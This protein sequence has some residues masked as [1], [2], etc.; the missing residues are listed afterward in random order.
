M[1]NSFKMDW[2]SQ[3]YK[4]LL[5][6]IGTVIVLA[7]L[8]MI[9]G[10]FRRHFEAADAGLVSLSSPMG[11]VSFDYLPASP[12]LKGWKLALP[13]KP[14]LKTEAAKDCPGGLRIEAEDAIDL[15]V[16]EYLKVCNRVSF[17]AK[18]SADSYVYA[19]IRMESRDGESHS[20]VGWIACAIGDRGPRRESRDEWV[21]YQVPTKSGWSNYDLFLPDVVEQ[22]FGTSEGLKFSELLGFRLR[23]TLSITRISLYR[24]EGP[25]PTVSTQSLS[26][27]R[28]RLPWTRSD[29]LQLVALAIATLGIVI[30]L[31]RSFLE[32]G[33]ARA[34]A[35]VARNE[36]KDSDQKVVEVQSAKSIEDLRA[37]NHVAPLAEAESAKTLAEIPAESFGYVD[38]SQFVEYAVVNVSVRSHK[39]LNEFE[40]H[41]LADGDGI[42]V[43][44]VGPETFFR[45]MEG[46]RHGASL[47]LYSSTWKEAPKLVGVAAKSIKCGRQR[48]IYVDNSSTF[49]SEVDALDCEAR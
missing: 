1:V 18:L 45:L 10:L 9:V 39:F 16:E 22:T 24:D 40:I 17:G 15:G 48:T 33:N 23:G 49:P 26:N 35:G 30:P 19:R 7:L 21:V 8:R 31:A 47:T 34:V 5:D 6:G 11:Q 3:N 2:F 37:Q 32:S 38:G 14:A 25:R 36:S 12:L 20:K 41:K 28:E 29:V 42:L 46:V 4:W 27:R 44:Y 13:T 43:G